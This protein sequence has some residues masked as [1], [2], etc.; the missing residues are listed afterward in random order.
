MALQLS[1]SDCVHVWHLPLD[2]TDLTAPAIAEI[3]ST[4]ELARS[5]RFRF[6]A[7]RHTFMV[8]H[9]LLRRILALYLGCSAAELSFHH[10]S[11][12]KPVLANGGRLRFNL[13]H[14]DK[15]AMLAVAS[16]EIGVDV[17]R[18]R[19]D[20]AWRPIAHHFFSEAER[21]HV[22]AAPEP[23]QAEAFF[24]CWTRREAY[25]KA[26]GLGIG[27]AEIPAGITNDVLFDGAKRWSICS[28]A[29]YDGY[30]AALAAE[31]S[32]CTCQVFDWPPFDWPSAVARPGFTHAAGEKKIRMN[33]AGLGNAMCEKEN[34]FP[35]AKS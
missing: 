17:E 25:A 32:R 9:A 31:G 22:E 7:D 24:R 14:A 1:T 26:C 23:M 15:V 4:D 8:A 20:F 28:V 27:I 3:L 18:F 13:S 29:A 35:G 19:P 10:G 6:A 12:G 11:H 34:S 21:R 16:R 30:V 5:A 2:R 33:G